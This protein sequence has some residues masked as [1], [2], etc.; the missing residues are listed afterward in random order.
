MRLT[1][2]SDP[3][4]SPRFE[5]FYLAKLFSQTTSHPLPADIDFLQDDGIPQSIR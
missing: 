5:L 2:I 1:L 3:D 4:G